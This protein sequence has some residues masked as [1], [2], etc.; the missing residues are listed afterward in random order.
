MYHA[1]TSRRSPCIM[2]LVCV[3]KE[4]KVR[5]A[6]FCWPRFVFFIA[7]QAQSSVYFI[8]LFGCL[9]VLTSTISSLQVVGLHMQGLGCDEMLQGFAVAIKMG[10]TKADFDNTVAI[11]PT[12]SEEFV[13]MR[14]CRHCPQPICFSIWPKTPEP[15]YSLIRVMTCFTKL[16]IILYF[17][18]LSD[19]NCKQC[20]YFSQIIYFT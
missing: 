15:E 12:S 4:E 3:G 10:A 19:L 14:W 1:I 6:C 9:C 8:F 5:I 2:K 17:L 20:S 13:T 16:I 18:H 7:F 11:H